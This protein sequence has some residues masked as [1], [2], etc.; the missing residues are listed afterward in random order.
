M[1]M[2]LLMLEMRRPQKVPYDPTGMRKSRGSMERE[3]LFVSRKHSSV[4]LDETL[5]AIVSVE[6]S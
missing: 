3:L 1:T 2:S 5:A 4:Q 6:W